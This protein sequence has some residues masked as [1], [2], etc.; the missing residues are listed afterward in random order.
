MA[1]S[2]FVNSPLF[3]SFIFLETEGKNSRLIMFNAHIY[4]YYIAYKIKNVKIQDFNF[5][6]LFIQ[7]MKKKEKLSEE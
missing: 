1:A 3:I 4:I 2:V 7:T 5:A 6:I